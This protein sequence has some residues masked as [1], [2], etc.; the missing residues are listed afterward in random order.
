MLLSMPDEDLR[1][2]VRTLEAGPAESSSPPLLN[3]RFLAASCAGVRGKKVRGFEASLRRSRNRTQYVAICGGVGVV[4]VR[5]L[6][7]AVLEPIFEQEGRHFIIN[8][9]LG[10]RGYKIATVF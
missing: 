10:F 3:F 4:V 2:K 8:A 6:S 9:Q 5:V 7:K 1:A